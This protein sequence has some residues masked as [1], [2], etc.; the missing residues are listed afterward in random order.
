MAV[1][2]AEIQKQ[3]AR[4]S[5]LAFMR[6]MWSQKAKLSVGFHTEQICNYIDRAMQRTKDGESVYGMI[7]VPFRHGK[8]ITLTYALAMLIGLHPEMEV[9][10]ATH[11]L[12]LAKLVSRNVR[13]LVDS[14]KFKALF[15]GVL[16]NPHSK[17]VERWEVVVQKDDKLVF[18]GGAF[19]IASTTS[20]TA[21]RG[22]E[23]LVL[24]DMFPNRARAESP[25]EQE[26]VWEFITNDFLSR[27]NP[28]IDGRGSFVFVL[29]TPWTVN[30][31]FA[32][33]EQNMRE[34]KNFP[35]FDIL[36]FPAR[37]ELY[38]GEG[39]Y[40]GEYLFEKVRA[41]R[42]GKEVIKPGLYTASWYESKY[43]ALGRVDASSLLD[44]YPIARQ[45]GM[46]DVASI[47]WTDDDS[48]W[49]TSGWIRTIDLAHSDGVSK[50]G[51]K[52]KSDFTG[53]TLVAFKRGKR[54][55]G[56]SEYYIDM[57]IRDYS[58]IRASAV[59]RDQWLYDMAMEDGKTVTQV[60]ERSLDSIDTINNMVKRLLG[61]RRVKAQEF[62]QNKASRV[63]AT[64]LPLFEGGRVHCLNF[65]LK[66]EW[67]NQISS[68][69][70]DE[71]GGAHDEAVDNLTLAY[72]YWQDKVANQYQRLGQL[73]VG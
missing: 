11:T 39:K 19:S 13:R 63:E 60:Y 37:A 8:T 34:D 4:Q 33:I 32:R 9:L 16:I 24:D 2:S 28:S 70:A 72:K 67:L 49:P 59:K 14:P 64:V 36:R 62:R 57:Y 55:E 68:F 47:D 17:S 58:Q 42:D 51:R 45:G 38:Q 65:P 43:A 71:S 15:P 50:A 41:F 56:T 30:D 21:G 46:I 73:S 7:N 29:G 53:A 40:P 52:N 35:Q 66:N 3:I 12:D 1:L 22:A 25:T 20:G 31:G 54:I 26:A 6:Y 61:I 48:D 10:Y 69:C 23:I 27:I 18:K 5:S 44:C